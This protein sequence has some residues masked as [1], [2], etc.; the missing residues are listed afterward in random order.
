MSIPEIRH[1]A[2][3]ISSTYREL[4]VVF[5]HHCGMDVAANQLHLAG[6]MASFAKRP[7]RFI[8]RAACQHQLR[9]SLKNL[10]ACIVKG[11]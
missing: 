5:V 7:S 4:F 10:M 11:V 1:Y 8:Y 3:T 6:F 2:A 9:F